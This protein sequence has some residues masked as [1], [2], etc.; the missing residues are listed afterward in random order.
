MSNSDYIN[1]YVGQPD[2]DPNTKH[3]LC[4]ADGELTPFLYM[5]F[6]SCFGQHG[7]FSVNWFLFLQQNYVGKL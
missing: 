4:G 3:C 6:C 2:H 5:I 7:K 1:F